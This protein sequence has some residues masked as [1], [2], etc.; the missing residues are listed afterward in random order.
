MHLS[1]AH[2]C[3]MQCNRLDRLKPFS[4]Q[5]CARGLFPRGPSN[6]DFINYNLPCLRCRY[7]LLIGGPAQFLS[8]RYDMRRY[9]LVLQHDFF[10]GCNSLG[11]ITGAREE[12]RML[13][14]LWMFGIDY[15]VLWWL[16]CIRRI[17]NIQRNLSLS[18]SWWQCSGRV[19]S[20][21]ITHYASW[22]YK[23]RKKVSHIELLWPMSTD[24]YSIECGTYFT[25]LTLYC[26]NRRS[27]FSISIAKGLL[28]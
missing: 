16:V 13:W 27:R 4:L 21:V 19:K 10:V 6:H 18:Y 8:F 5:P 1:W 25:Y 9:K 3:N 23:N 24:I 20:T 15:H 26:L 28:Y 11:H 22:Q 7:V 17:E 12:V 14:N 2:I